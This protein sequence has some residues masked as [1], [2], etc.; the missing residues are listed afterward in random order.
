MNFHL[1]SI[2]EGKQ[3]EVGEQ[4]NRNFKE[5]EFNLAD[6]EIGPLV[7]IGSNSAVYGARLL[8]AVTS[9]KLCLCRSC[10]PS[11]M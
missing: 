10:C 7:A 5:Q 8:S 9:G 3:S 2:F 6:L 11:L 4:N 1:Q